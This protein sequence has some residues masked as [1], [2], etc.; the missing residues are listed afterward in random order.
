M[1]ASI[2]WWQSAHT[3]NTHFITQYLYLV[4]W[5]RGHSFIN[6]SPYLLISTFQ[7]CIR[8]W[9][10]SNRRKLFPSLDFSEMERL[11]SKLKQP[12]YNKLTSNMIIGSKLPSNS[13]NS[14]VNHSGKITPTDY[15]TNSFPHIT[16]NDADAWDEASESDST[17]PS[18]LESSNW[19]CS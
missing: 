1:L 7:T 3:Q 14:K 8:W 19:C 5:K 17:S 13:T 2:S 16:Y 6:A 12:F 11:T 4:E 9:W 15:N 10:W 18:T